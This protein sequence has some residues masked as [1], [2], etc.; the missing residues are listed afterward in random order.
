MPVTPGRLRPGRGPSRGSPEG[1]NSRSTR[2]NSRSTRL[3]SRSTRRTVSSRSTPSTGS[4]TTRRTGSRGTGSRGTGQYQPAYAYPSRNNGKAT[5]A[6]WTG[7][8]SLVLTP[9]CGAGILGILPIVLGVKARSEIRAT[10]QEGDGMALAGIITGI[11]SVVLS[12]VIIA[13]LA[14]VISSGNA[15]FDGTLPTGV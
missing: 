12:V 7:V 6:L 4:R 15:D 8:G 9:C 3:S 10:G 5:A 14:V 2:L 11:V 1:R 13:F